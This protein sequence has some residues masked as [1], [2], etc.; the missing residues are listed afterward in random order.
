MEIPTC[1]PRLNL[2][3]PFAA[4]PRAAFTSFKARVFLPL[5]AQVRL[6]NMPQIKL[7][8]IQEPVARCRPHYPISLLVEIIV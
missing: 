4:H 3:P 2:L 1:D 7:I 6:H 5:A 8:S